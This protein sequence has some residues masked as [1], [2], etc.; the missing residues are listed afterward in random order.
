MLQSSTVLVVTAVR[1]V[2]DRLSPEQWA[3]RFPVHFDDCLPGERPDTLAIAGLPKRWFCP[4]G[5]EASATT[6]AAMAKKVFSTFGNVKDAQL[7]P[8]PAAAVGGFE[9]TFG[10]HVQYNAFADFCRACASLRGRKLVC[11]WRVL[12]SPPF[13]PIPTASALRP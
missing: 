5:E 13:T 6:L 2:D 12:A 7:I 8:V 3:H 11:G 1:S 9:L 4:K 10:V